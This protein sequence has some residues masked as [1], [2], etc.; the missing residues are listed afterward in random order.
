[1][2]F[3][4]PLS[5]SPT[6]KSLQGSRLPMT[7]LVKSS[8]VIGRCY[9]ECL[10]DPWMIKVMGHRRKDGNHCFERCDRI[11]QLKQSLTVKLMYDFCIQITMCKLRSYVATVLLQRVGGREGDEERKRSTRHLLLLLDASSMEQGQKACNG[12]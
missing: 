4:Y 5:L 7:Y 11:T 9:E 12:W 8:Q 2:D 1:M 6:L 10:V 3:N